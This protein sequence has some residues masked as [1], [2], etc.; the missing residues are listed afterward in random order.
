M[1]PIPD[2]EY[3]EADLP[4]A[5]AYPYCYEPHPIAVAAA[6]RLREKIPGSS[7]P[8]DSDHRSITDHDDN[9]P[10]GKMMGVLVIRHD[11]NN[12]YGRRLGYLKA[13]S[14]TL[15]D[16]TIIRREDIGLCPPVYD[17]RILQAG[18]GGADRPDA[19]DRADGAR[20]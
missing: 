10:V 16:D 18:G 2:D 6:D 14:G 19:S 12:G 7:H 1:N 9:G 15:P 11:G 3:D 13:Y 8:N 5:F 4:R 17:Q 20:S